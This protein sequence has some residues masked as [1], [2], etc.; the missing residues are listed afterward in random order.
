MQSLDTEVNRISFSDES[1]T[2]QLFTK[3]FRLDDFRL[4]KG[5]GTH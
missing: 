1:I 2:D 4:L 5:F 3:Y